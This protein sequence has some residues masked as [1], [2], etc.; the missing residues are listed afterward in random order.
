MQ[1]TLAFS[2]DLADDTD[3]AK[4]L[5][6]AVLAAFVSLKSV[7]KDLGATIASTGSMALPVARGGNAGVT[8]AVQT[9]PAAAEAA[10]TS[11]ANAEMHEFFEEVRQAEAPAEPRKP[12]GRK[13]KATAEAETAAAVNQPLPLDTPAQREPADQFSEPVESLQELIDLGNSVCKTL[14]PKLVADTLKAHN[15]G[16]YSGIPQEKWTEVAAGWRKAL[17]ASVK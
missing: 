17:H 15:A 11:P 12:R 4:K 8:A 3:H 13:P 16:R 6:D 1:A 2:L 14:G 5:M 7:A 10:T 9:A